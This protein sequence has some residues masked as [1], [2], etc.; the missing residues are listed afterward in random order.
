MT[1][2]LRPPRELASVPSTECPAEPTE[3][4]KTERNEGER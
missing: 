2:R 1:Q 3:R 4:N